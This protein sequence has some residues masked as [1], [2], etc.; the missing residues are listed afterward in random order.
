MQFIK[1]L[2]WICLIF[3][4]CHITICPVSAKEYIFS[5]SESKGFSIAFMVLREAYQNIG[6]DI[7][8]EKFTSARALIESNNGRTDGE[9]GRVK[10]IDRTFK[11]LLRVPVPVLTIQFAAFSKDNTIQIKGWESLL[12]Y[13]IAYIRG[14]KCI[15]KNLP[16]GARVNLLTRQEHLFMFIEKNRADIAITSLISSHFVLKSKDIHSI[17]V[18]G[19]LSKVHL[20]HYLH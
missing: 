15:K 19:K 16:K 10:G 7:K 3:L 4:Y 6:I 13:E 1:Q 18:V 11:N 20:Y 14:V 8:R 17:H 9:I 2:L 12:P 5:S